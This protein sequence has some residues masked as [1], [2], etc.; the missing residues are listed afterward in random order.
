MSL[1][2]ISFLWGMLTILAPCVWPLLPIIIGTS[3]KTNKKQS[4]HKPLIVIGSFA[5][6][7]VIFSLLINRLANQFWIFQEN[8]VLISWWILLVVGILIIFPQ[9]WDWI[10]HKSKIEQ[11]TW[12]LA[13]KQKKWIRW[14]IAIWALLWPLLQSCSPTYTILIAMIL[15]WNFL[16][17]VINIIAYVAGLSLLLLVIVYGW[18]TAMN[19]FN[20]AVKPGGWFRIIVWLIIAIMG[21][22][23]VNWYDK[24]LSNRLVTNGIAIDTT[25][26]ENNI[27]QWVNLDDY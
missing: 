1:I 7:V 15:P 2:A 17:G 10:M 23:V 14:D 18:R 8:I 5:A 6:S 22:L 12:Q 26:I 27:I 19:K 20:R 25:M 4:Q 24:D 16:R 21:F 11:K 13:S 3:V 9:P